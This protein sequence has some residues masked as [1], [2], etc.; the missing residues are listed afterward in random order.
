MS[1]FFHPLDDALGTRSKVRILRV[2]LGRDKG[3]SGRGVGR[4]ANVSSQ[5]AFRALEDLS[6]LGLVRREESPAEHRFS[7]NR[8]HVLVKHGLE[9]L[10]AAEDRAVDAVFDRLQTICARLDQETP[11]RIRAAW[12]FGSAMK[13]ED[14][15]ASDLDLLL[16]TD[17][18]EGTNELRTELADAHGELEEEYGLDLSPVVLTRDRLREMDDDGAALARAVREDARRVFGSSLREV[19]G[20]PA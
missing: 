15:P 1:T 6:D 4:R 8:R 18:E 2:L 10:F 7:I 12:L 5:T 9:G 16:V 13:G 11:A 17:G 14:R 19:L 20:G 3:L